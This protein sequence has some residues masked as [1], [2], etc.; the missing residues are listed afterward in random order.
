MLSIIYSSIHRSQRKLGLVMSR[1]VLLVS[2]LLLMVFTS[3]FE[4]NQLIVNE[5]EARP[6]ALSQKEQ[7]ILEKEE[8]VKEKIILSQEKQIQKLK[9]LVQSLQEQL[10]VCK[11]KDDFV[12]DTTGSL[13]EI[14]NE[15]NHHQI[16][17]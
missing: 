8:S 12:N 1:P 15:L 17:E 10:L 3:Q 14:L 5:V 13:T 9:T 4:W 6:L 16:M 2:L 7:Y 11:G